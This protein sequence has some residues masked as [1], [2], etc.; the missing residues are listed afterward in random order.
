MYPRMAACRAISR[1]DSAR[2]V[3]W[4]RG[5]TRGGKR[6]RRTCGGT[7]PTNKPSVHARDRYRE[8]QPRS[9][10]TLR[11]CGGSAAAAGASCALPQAGAAHWRAQRVL[12]RT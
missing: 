10:V 3:H 11:A 4:L 9:C 1:A 8:R 7:P 6:H 5:E 2:G 12:Q